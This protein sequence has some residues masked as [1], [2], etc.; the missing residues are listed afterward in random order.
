MDA[1]FEVITGNLRNK[2]RTIITLYEQNK[3]KTKEL[4]SKNK[5]LA[6]KINFLEKKLA[7]T[8][9]KYSNMKLAKS[10]IATDDG[11]HDARI[12]MNR[13]VRE[14]DKCIALLNR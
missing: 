14:I 1:N 10:I 4:E 6:D 7:E 9:E 12:K 5:E 13:I 2:F 3:L 11:S 8:E